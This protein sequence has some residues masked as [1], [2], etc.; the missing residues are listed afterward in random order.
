MIQVCRH[1][2]S[3]IR[4]TARYCDQCG[5]PQAEDAVAAVPPAA[6]ATA[7]AAAPSAQKPALKPW[8]GVIILLVVVGG[9]YFLL[10]P[11]ASGGGA[12]GPMAGGQGGAMPAQVVEEIKAFKATM[13][14]NPA[15]VETI[16]KMYDLYAQVG[17]TDEVTPYVETAM[18][19][20]EKKPEDPNLR[21][22]IAQVAEA[23][24]KAGDDKAL[25]TCLVTFQHVFPEEKEVL[26]YLGDQCFRMGQLEE[27]IG[28][29]DKYI[30]KADPHVDD[31]NYWNA[32]I[33]RASTR[34]E[35]FKQNK[36]NAA[37]TQAITELEAA[38]KK[39]G[40]SWAAWYYLGDAYNEKADKGKARE[41]FVSS[42]GKATDG[43][44]RWQ[45]EAAIAKIDGKP[46]PPMPNPHGGP[47]SPHGEGQMGDASGQM[48]NDSVH[49]G[50]GSA[51]GAPPNDDIHK[52][53]GG[54]SQGEPPND[55][56]HKG[57][58]GSG[59]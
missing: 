55:D 10:K 47:G 5:R 28:W 7:S 39:K 20:L 30:E 49:S 46:E 27:S 48:P 21:Q 19:E 53:M 14:K 58:H 31:D 32:Y 51:G 15:D 42:Q 45:S 4:D 59:T 12:G 2:G 36:D 8:M 44:Q 24:S 50:M 26:T 25:L 54:G 1:C 38:T 3:E 41:A 23:A 17:K 22:N 52:G 9:L 57:V 37:L 40:E 35:L 6:S 16:A 56:I 29:Y 43:F 13:K 18:Q 33:A 11:E 34:T